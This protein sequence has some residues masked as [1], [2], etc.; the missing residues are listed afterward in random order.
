MPYENREIILEEELS[1]N[2]KA[3]PVIECGP[4]FFYYRITLLYPT[5]PGRR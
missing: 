5:K 1:G 3:T 4:E 2:K